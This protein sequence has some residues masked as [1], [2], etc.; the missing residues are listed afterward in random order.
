[1]TR[2]LLAILW[3][4]ACVEHR[5]HTFPYP[6]SSSGPGDD[7]SSSSDGGESSSDGASSSDGSGSSGDGG[8]DWCM[9]H[10]IQTT[11][12]KMCVC[13]TDADCPPD[14]VCHEYTNQ[15]YWGKV[16]L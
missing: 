6:V 1:M 11:G 3:I 4:C 16:C 10:Y 7:G 12:G 8:E 2:S 13:G 15:V 14:M 5:D 9:T